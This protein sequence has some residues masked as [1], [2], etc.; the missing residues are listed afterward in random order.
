MYLNTLDICF[1]WLLCRVQ[2]GYLLVR[3]SPILRVLCLFWCFWCFWRRFQS[4]QHIL[5]SLPH[6][7]AQVPYNILGS[8]RSC[9]WLWYSQGYLL[10]S[11]RQVFDLLTA[12][13]AALL[14]GSWSQ[15]SPWFSGFSKVLGRTDLR[16]RETS[17]EVFLLPSVVWVS[18]QGS[19]C[20]D[21]PLLSDG[22]FSVVVV[23]SCSVRRRGKT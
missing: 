6:E 4:G 12:R 16:L 13:L 18:R 21:S 11:R 23:S 15:S 2:S 8:L 7:M 20:Q 10:C 14:A 3:F 9:C 22:I 5:S 1:L 17:R 19:F